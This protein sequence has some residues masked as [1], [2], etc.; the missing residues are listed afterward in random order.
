M[1]ELGPRHGLRV[2]VPELLRLDLGL[3]EGHLSE[4]FARV[5]CIGAFARD[6]R[7][8]PEIGASRLRTPVLSTAELFANS[9][10][11]R[12]QRLKLRE[13]EVAREAREPAV[14]VD[15]QPLGRHALEY[16]SNS[17]RDQLGALDV[18]VLEIEHTGTELPGAVELAP[19]LAL[20]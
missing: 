8:W 9:T 19:Q 15:P 13:R 7:G 4:L 2:R 16:P 1:V 6:H 10:R 20:D 12:D 11:A 17:S 5:H 14:R 3:V 18:E